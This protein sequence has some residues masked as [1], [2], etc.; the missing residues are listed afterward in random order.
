[1]IEVAILKNFDSG[2]YKAGVQL[3]GSLTTY[4][5]NINVAKNIPT[6]AMITGNYV[7]L[8]IPGG[9]PKD[10]CVIATWPQGTPGGGGGDMYKS[11]YDTDDDAVVDAA[12]LAAD[13]LKLQ[14]S[15]K[16][17]V[18]DHAPNAHKTSHQDGGSDELSVAG[19]A[20]LLATPQT[21]AAH[22]TSHDY[23]GADEF[24]LIRP[25]SQRLIPFINKVWTDINGFTAAHVGTGG[26][27]IGFLYGNL[28]TGTTNNSR[29]LIYDT[30][31]FWQAYA[32]YGYSWGTKLSI[33]QGTTQTIWIGLL[34]VPETPSLTQAHVA[35]YLD[36]SGNLWASSGNGTNGTQTDTGLDFTSGTKDWYL[37][38][39]GNATGLYF[40]VNHVLKATHLL[41]SSY[42]PNSI[43]CHFTMYIKNA[44]DGATRQVF[45]YPLN[46]FPQFAY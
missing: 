19:L 10:A 42:Y 28:Y 23:L 41:A 17:E 39:Y 38:I 12:E 37:S 29:G 5:D 11:V 46:M 3:A 30:A 25:I 45:C 20:G 34:N 2:T 27:T 15:T 35:F 8:A 24:P 16:A 4:F 6:T 40:Y 32:G 18:R 22:K 21:P 33:R 13:S 1:M 7:I 9:N 43:V 31:G 44:T 36:T 26:F 14:G